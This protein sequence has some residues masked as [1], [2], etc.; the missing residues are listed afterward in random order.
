MAE[1]WTRRARRWTSRAAM[2]AAILALAVLL[3]RG[4][5]AQS[6]DLGPAR[7][8]SWTFLVAAGA[9]AAL[10]QVTRK[11]SGARAPARWTVE[12]CALS[13]V[14]ALALAQLG[15][16]LSSP[17]YPL[18]YLLGAGYALALPLR[19]ALPAL[20][21]LL[22]LDA[23]LF[24]AQGALPV[25][26]PLFATHAAFTGVFAALYHAVLAA[27][28]RAA[29]TAEEEA[30]RRRV[31]DAERSAREFRL[32]ATAPAD[33]DRQILAAVS[34]IEESVRGALS[35]AAAALQPHTVAVF[36][37]S[38]DGA[39]VR[40]RDSI[41]RSDHLFRGPLPTREG[42]LGAVLAAARPVLL[43]GDGPALSHYDGPA[44]VH[45]FCGVPLR[46]RQERV[47][48]ALVADREAAFA[49]ADE[50]VLTSLAGGVRRGAGARD[51]RARSVRGDA[52]RGA[53][54]RR[55]AAA[56]PRPVG[57]GRRFRTPGGPHLR[58][59]PRPGR[60]RGPAGSSAARPRAAGDGARGHL[61]LG[62]RRAGP[63]RAEDLPHARGRDHRGHPGVR[64]APPRR[65]AR[66]G[67]G[68]AGDA[69]AAGR[70][71]AGAHAPVRAGRAAGHHRRPHRSAEPT[72]AVRAA[73]GA[74]P[75]GAAL[76][77][78]ALAP[79]ARRRPLQEGE[80]HA[81]PP[82]GRCR[83]ARGLG[84]GALAGAR[85]R[86]GGA[87]WRRGAGGGPARDR[88]CGR[89]NHR[90]AAPGGGRRDFPRHRA[91]LVA[92]HRQRGRR[93]LAGRGAEPG[94]A[95][96]HRR[97][98]AVPGQ[99][100]RAESRRVRPRKGSGLRTISGFVSGPSRSTLRAKGRAAR[101]PSLRKNYVLDTNVLLHDPSAL[102]K[103]KD[104]N[105]IVP[106]YVVEE[107]DKFKRDLSEL[108]R[109]ARQVSR[110]LDAL[111]AE[112]GSLTEGVPLEGGGTLRVLFTQKELPR[113]LMNGHLADNRILALASDIKE[114]EPNLRCVF[115][116]KD[117]NLRIRADALGLPSE[118][119]R[120]D[121]IENPEVYM[122][123]REVETSRAEIDS[124][125]AHGELPVPE[126]IAGTVCP[127][128]FALL[129]DRD[130]VSHTALAKYHA[131]K[132]KFVP[133]LKSLKEGAWGLRPRNK[134]QSF[135]LDLLLNDEIKLVTMVGKAGTGKTLLAIAAGLQKTM[136][137]Q[138]F[139]KML[140][141]R[142]VFPLGKDIG[143]LPG[144]VEEKLNPW[145]QPIYDNVEFLMGLSRADK[146]AGRSYKELVDLG[147]VAIE[148]LTYIRGR[149]IPNQYII[150]DEAQNLTPH[151][152]KT[153]ITRVGDNTKIVLTGDPYQIDNPYVDSTNNG[154]IHVVNK[155]RSE[156]LAGH[157]TLTKGERSALAEL[158]SNVL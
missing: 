55:S 124:F 33:P 27:R 142:P 43:Q 111:R 39:T 139:Q 81:R 101:E 52:G 146:K 126:P 135:A 1:H 152:V 70:R 149:S 151:E 104:N 115:V 110:D 157:I 84:G 10:R 79:P 61:R 68:C 156:R 60:Q 82:G 129:K 11:L 30:V 113:E 76:P 2:P 24:L 92:R 108:G 150:V 114:R 72:H 127:N 154:L 7:V 31:A 119:Y 23:G 5:F 47:L 44:P 20:G 134:E 38:P 56:P 137:E 71:G 141:S 86:P 21:W 128:E 155:F 148:P 89:A 136:E 91:G 36:L 116:S 65:A 19:F 3:V 88:R 57:R 143:Y 123:V 46:D 4:A 140:V 83:A 45:C 117:V 106:I 8:A 122:G 98:G 80:R 109:N 121:K 133:L 100:D 66:P 158:A 105:V 42:A 138:V 50:Q 25:R 34:E 9:W 28:L 112:G 14:G 58:R 120:N 95:A 48:G 32:V 64:N 103:F 67:A 87:L 132:G 147:L 37:L 75:G 35:V 12:A 17:L 144:S 107:I 78:A 118:D 54:A 63:G 69:G 59:Q 93:H 90:G 29:R 40:L 6:A 26:W 85:D 74:G 125:Y 15:G 99:A 153:I 41:S 16:G 62:H 145:M 49:P 53:R 73:R 94:R 77:P 18:V 102:F 51:G 13:A 96:H 130:A 97:P 22:G 131:G